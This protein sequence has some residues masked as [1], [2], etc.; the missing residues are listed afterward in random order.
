MNAL[1][2]LFLSTLICALGGGPSRCIAVPTMSAY[3]GISARVW[4]QDVATFHRRARSASNNSTT[5]SSPNSSTNGSTNASNN[6]STN[7][8]TNGSTNSSTNGSTNSSTN[9]STNGSTNGWTNSSSNGNNVTRNLGPELPGNVTNEI[10]C[11]I[12]NLLFDIESM[13]LSWIDSDETGTSEE[14]SESAEISLYVIQRHRRALVSQIS[15]LLPKSLTSFMQIPVDY[16]HESMD[17]AQNLI[18]QQIS[19][20]IDEVISTVLNF[21]STK[22]LPAIHSALNEMAKTDRLPAS[23]NNMIDQFNSIYEILKFLRFIRP[24][25][26]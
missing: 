17:S 5:N 2:I 22:G 7:S 13:L 14:T 19:S 11:A 21:M 8:S 20:V 16:L 1:A 18:G 23:V 12:D 26:N 25:G 6:G 9:S 3:Q 24:N 15:D 10:V 4:D